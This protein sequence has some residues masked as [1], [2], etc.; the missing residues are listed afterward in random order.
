[1][2]Q[3]WNDAYKSMWEGRYKNQEYAYGKA[4]ND[5]FKQCLDKLHPGSILMPADGEG[6]NGVY[7]AQKGWTVTSFDF[8][9]EAR[10]KAL[11]LAAERQVSIDYLVGDLQQLD[12]PDASFDAIGL[13]YAH[14]A[15]DRK[16][17]YHKKLIHFLKPGG[18][19]IFEA[20]SKKHLALLSENP[21]VG[22]PRDID[23]L[24]SKEEIK[25]DFRHFDILE[26]EEVEVLLDE[27][28][29]HAGKGS[30][31]RFLGRKR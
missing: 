19:V 8:S 14:F 4:P 6:R 26:L 11:H 27:G 28:P 23:M 7:A 31:I 24:F 21:K 20:F 18:R 1:M 29:Y 16:S 5:F 9:V 25:A 12:L 15:A 22:G 13:I 30:V 3:A 17:S 2:N 10:A